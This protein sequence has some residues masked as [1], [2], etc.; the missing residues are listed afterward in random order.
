MKYFSV[1]FQEGPE[2]GCINPWCQTTKASKL[3][4][5]A[6][7]ICGSSVWNLFNVNFL[8]PRIFMWLLG[9]GKFVQPWPRSMSVEEILA[10]VS[11]W[12]YT[13]SQ[14]EYIHW[15]TNFENCFQQEQISDINQISMN[16]MCYG[17]ALRQTIH[18]WGYHHIQQA[19]KQTNKSGMQN[20]VYKPRAILW[21]LLCS[22]WLFETVFVF[23]LHLHHEHE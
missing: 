8:S 5:V 19:I 17:Q 15:H 6:P 16:K 9:L 21:N 2:Q 23:Y 14:E 20:I 1:R 11:V 7:N 3:C 12:I 18:I 22:Q 4:K 10:I 13:L